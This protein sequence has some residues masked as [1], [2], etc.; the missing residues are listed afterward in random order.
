MER[1]SKR[2]RMSRDAGAYSRLPYDV[3]GIVRKFSP[4][5]VALVLDDAFRVFFTKRETKKRPI[6]PSQPF[7]TLAFLDEYDRLTVLPTAKHPDA[8]VYSELPHDVQGFVR[9]FTP[10]PV[11]LLVEDAH[12]LWW[13]LKSAS[14][15]WHRNEQSRVE[16]TERVRDHNVKVAHFNWLQDRGNYDTWVRSGVTTAVIMSDDN[17][18]Y[19]PQDYMP[20]G[21]WDF[22]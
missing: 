9:K 16:R 6:A 12:D 20:R 15:H 1:P 8:S 4:H 3:Q 17:D 18:P 10:H 11:S 21:W 13:E 7:N 14:I 5:P 2:V 22:F 19:D